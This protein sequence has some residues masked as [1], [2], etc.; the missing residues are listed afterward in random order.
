VVICP[1]YHRVGWIDKPKNEVPGNQPETWVA[2]E[3]IR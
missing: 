3:R 2:V 1:L